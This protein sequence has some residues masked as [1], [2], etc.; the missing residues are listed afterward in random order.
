MVDTKR[1]L[2]QY[3]TSRNPFIHHA[4]CEWA[5]EAHIGL[6]GFL[7]PFAGAGDILRLLK[8]AGLATRA[9]GYDIAPACEWATQRDTLADFPEG[10]HAVVTNPPYLARNSASRRH[11]PYP[12]TRYADL[13]LHALDTCL[14]HTPYV[15]AIIP[16]SFVTSGALKD[17]LRDVVSLPYA[18]MFSDTEHPVCLAMFGPNLAQATTRI[19]HG[20]RLIGVLDELLASAPKPSGSLAM[21]FNDPNGSVAL[22]GV[23][24]QKSA[25][26]RFDIGAAVDPSEVK[27]SSRAKT[28]IAISGLNLSLV[29]PVIIA[30]NSILS[31]RRKLTG[32][33]GMTAFKGVRR[34]GCFRRRLDFSEARG[35]LEMAV[36]QARDNMAKTQ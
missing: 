23:D 17:R 5:K 21:R 3:Y 6:N 11:L 12:Q 24:D 13:Y 8:D 1:E 2:G 28:R 26:I 9:I 15:A 7:E 36:A 4:F 30:A 16:E 20:E 32:D 31:K 22:L 14:R 19:W 29:D 18:D 33:V 34:D 35:I 27:H 10:H 25:T